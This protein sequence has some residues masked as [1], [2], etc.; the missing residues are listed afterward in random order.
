MD[1]D[2]NG[3]GRSGN[4]VFSTLNNWTGANVPLE[5]MRIDDAGNVGIGTAAPSYK[6]HVQTDASA[7]Y[8][9][10]IR[11]AVAG[12]N[13]VPAGWTNLGSS[14]GLSRPSDASVDIAGMA[15][16]GNNDLAI[17]ARLNMHFTTNG[18]E[19]VTFLNTGSAFSVGIGNTN[20][21]YKLDVS[22]TL[23]TTSD[24]QMDTHLVVT[25]DVTSAAFL[26]SSDERLKRNIATLGG[27]LGKVRQLRGVS[28]DW[29]KDGRPGIGVI[30]QEVEKV[31]PQLVA[32]NKATGMKA[33]EYGNLVGPLVEAVK[34]LAVKIE[35]WWAEL[36]DL[37]ARVT[38]LENTVNTQQKAIEE[39]RKEIKDI[40]GLKTRP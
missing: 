16:T 23:H 21:T 5:R 14:I 28:F 31:Y 12:T 20:P 38:T 40:K 7:N 39:L 17:G 37:K 11:D 3:I 27:S 34:E 36:T 22:G 32:T 19:G 10:A 24:V 18:S 26:Y 1:P 6:L 15:V 33:V 35:T 9:V 2:Y 8:F 29:K 30:A 25:T 4:I 13:I